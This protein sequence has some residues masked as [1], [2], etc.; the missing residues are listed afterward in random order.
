MSAI[1]KLLEA[2]GNCQTDD[3]ANGNGKPRRS[4]RPAS[5]QFPLTDT[6]LAERFAFQ[7]AETARYCHQ[8]GKWLV[9]DGKRWKPDDSGTVEQLAKQT[10]RNILTEAYNEPNDGRR[11]ALAEFSAKSESASKR[12]AMLTL[13]RSE[14]PLPITPDLLD[15][16]AWVLN[17]P[18][19]E[20]NL[21]TG[22]LSEHRRESLITKLCP[23]EYHPD[24]TCPTWE[25][26]LDR[27]LGGDAELVRFVQRYFGYCSTGDVGE[28]VLGIWHGIGAN[29][30]STVLNIGMEMLGPYAMKAP[31]ELLLAKRDSGHPTALTDL[32]GKRLASCIETDDGRRLAEA[33]VKELTGGDPIRAR[34]MREDFWQFMP[35]HKIILACN[36]KPRV[37][38]TD[39]AIWRRI[40]LVPFNVVIPPDERDRDLPNKLRSELPGILAWTIRGCLDWQT[41]GLGEPQAVA[42]ATS[43]YQ[44]AEDLLTTFV[45]ECC[46]LEGD[47]RTRAADV[48][49]AYINWGGERGMTV[50]RLTTMLTERGIESFRSGGLWYRVGLN[51]GFLD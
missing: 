37:R 40:K 11:R 33:L 32:H 34:R 12:N 23:V 19:G 3:T 21:R 4:R 17:C 50:R 46:A 8:W 29:G 14:P 9:W 44:C 51:A 20:L 6:G 45:M 36:H 38:G 5:E 27:C 31:A 16:N 28:Q 24:A 1:R 35:T 18:N 30:K 10:A 42:N 26:T 13:A 15:K 7:H 2:S 22:E 49:N 43:E 47:V 25:K 41:N 48:L 39:H